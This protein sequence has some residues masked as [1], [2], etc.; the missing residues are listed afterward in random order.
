MSTLAAILVVVSWNMSGIPAI[1]SVLKAQKSESTVMIVTFLV[2]IFISMTTAI[3]IGMLL[4]AYFF[5]RKMVELSSFT[6]LRTELSEAEGDGDLA[7]TNILS[8]RTIPKN[9]LVYEIEGPLFFGSI[10]KFEQALAQTD[11]VYKVL[12]LRMRNTIYVD[13]GGL[14]II[15]Q[16]NEDCKQKKVILIL[17]DIH[18]QPYMLAM[19]CGLD[20]KI[21]TENIFGNLYEALER[22]AALTGVTYEKQTY[23]PTVVREKK[24]PP[25]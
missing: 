14:Y 5:I 9:I 25:K 17:S 3:E 20:Q 8:L 22:A 19:K 1:K 10:Q 7:D 18:T 23:E 6:Q 24:A 16:L 21:G 13:Q 11:Y 4:A 2:T 15:A 12:I